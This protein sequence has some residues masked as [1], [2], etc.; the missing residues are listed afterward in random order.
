[1]PAAQSYRAHV[2][3]RLKLALVHLSLLILLILFVF[4][5]VLVRETF[6]WDMLAPDRRRGWYVLVFVVRPAGARTC[7]C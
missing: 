1:M 7:P 3:L 2:M 4:V 6:R 5:L